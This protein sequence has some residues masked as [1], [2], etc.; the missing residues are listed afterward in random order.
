MNA[1]TAWYVLDRVETSDT[2]EMH[3]ELRI[4]PESLWFSGHFPGE[5]ILPGIAQ[6]GIAYD[7]VC[8]ALGCRI[9]ISGFSRVKFKKII[10][11]G[12]SLKVIITPKEDRQGVYLFRIVAGDDLACSG[13]MTLGKRTDIL[14]A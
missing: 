2:G 11:P 14:D 4:P 6:L 10:R 3:T 12:D 5:P 1:A 7:A 8:K 9:N 13:S